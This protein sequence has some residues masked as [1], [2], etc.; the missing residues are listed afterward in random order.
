MALRWDY[1]TT[2]EKV[3]RLR[4]ELDD[5]MRD[6]KRLKKAIEQQNTVITSM[7]FQIARLS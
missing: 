4:K 6:N 5:V 2:E 7:G 1:I 3:E